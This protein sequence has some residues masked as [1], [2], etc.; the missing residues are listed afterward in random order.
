[1]TQGEYNVIFVF[2]SLFSVGN[3]ILQ[4][5]YFL[6]LHIQKNVHLFK[7]RKALKTFIYILKVMCDTKTNHIKLCANAKV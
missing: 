1:M 3:N 6:E 7:H 4:S 5:N 2:I